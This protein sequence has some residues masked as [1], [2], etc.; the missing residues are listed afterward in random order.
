MALHALINTQIFCF[1]KILWYQG[2]QQ[3][4][5]SVIWKLLYNELTQYYGVSLCSNNPQLFIF[6]HIF[7]FV[8]SKHNNIHAGSHS[9]KMNN[10]WNILLW[11]F[12]S[13]VLIQ[14]YVVPIS[15]NKPQFLIFCASNH[16]SQKAFILVYIVS[17]W[18]SRILQWIQ[19]SCVT[20][21]KEY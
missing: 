15:N 9:I 5:I 12:N 6:V 13:C 7:L 19:N 4:C 11:I 18:I 2:N 17:E 20:V 16:F 14:Y 10:W 3:F 21:L 1:Y 8:T